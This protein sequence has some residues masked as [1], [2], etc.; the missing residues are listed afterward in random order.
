LSEADR[1]NVPIIPNEDKDKSILQVIQQVNVELAR[2]FTGSTEQIFGCVVGKVKERAETPSWRE[3]AP[4]LR[5][6]SRS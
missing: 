6:L 3:I 2:H 4:L 1:C 5:D